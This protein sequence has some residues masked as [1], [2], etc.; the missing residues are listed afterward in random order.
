MKAMP[1]ALMLALLALPLACAAASFDC[2]RAR[3]KLN[4][5]ICSDTELSRLD[6]KVWNTYGER[7][8][9][10]SALQYANVRERHILWR[11]TRGIYEAT[12][13]ALTHEYRNHLA[14]L[15]HPLLGLEGRYQRSGLNAGTAHFETEVDLR[16]PLTLELRG[17]VTAPAAI[18][19]QATARGESTTGT[20]S[21]L[22]GP[23]APLSITMRPSS[24]GG[25]ANLSDACEFAITF[26]GDDAVLTASESCGKAFDGRYAR[27]ARE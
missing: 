24:P 27:T 17:L 3:S 8:H 14:W 23:G 2:D 15:S 10:L 20:P 16:S 26:E 4:R 21:A 18:A 5:L 7:I 12:V 19:W 6:E 25:G 1:R 9:G 22:P 13:E 11:R